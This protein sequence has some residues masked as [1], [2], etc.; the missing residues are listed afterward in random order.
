MKVPPFD[1]PNVFS[2]EK[3]EWKKIKTIMKK[4]LFFQIGSF[5]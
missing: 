1:F 2:G 3:I 5:W 4:N